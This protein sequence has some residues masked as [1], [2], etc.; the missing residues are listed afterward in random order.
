MD[1]LDASRSR[2][3]HRHAGSTASG[4][5]RR[6]CWNVPETQRADPLKVLG[7]ANCGKRADMQEI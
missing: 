6:V 3:A 7:A 2:G 5:V 1:S 4:S